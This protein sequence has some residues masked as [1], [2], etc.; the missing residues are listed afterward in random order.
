MLKLLLVILGI[1][2]IQLFFIITLNIFCLNIF[3]CVQESTLPV[4]YFNYIY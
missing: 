1:S 3:R 4:N 2:V